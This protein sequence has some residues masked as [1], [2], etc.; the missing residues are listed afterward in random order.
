MAALT[1][2]QPVLSAPVVVTADADDPREHMTDARMRQ[3]F[4]SVYYRFAETF[5]R[6]KRG[7]YRNERTEAKYQGFK[8][9]LE[10]LVTDDVSLYDLTRVTRGKYDLTPLERVDD[11]MDYHG[12]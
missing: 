4:E 9:A 7:S 5:E 1:C 8:L 6:G 3:A 10:S 12:C 11:S 2:Y